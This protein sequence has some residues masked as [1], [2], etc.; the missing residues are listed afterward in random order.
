MQPGTVHSSIYEDSCQQFDWKGRFFAD[1]PKYI[2]R[3]WT[4]NG[5]C[6]IGESYREVSETLIERNAR[7]L[8]GHNP[9][10]LCLQALPFPRGREYDGFEVAVHDLAGKLLGVPVSSLLGGAVRDRIPVSYWTGRRTPDDMALIAAKALAGGFTSL[11]MKC[12]LEDPHR[13][14]LERIREVCGPEFEVVLDP[15]QR[16][17]IPVNAMRIAGELKGFRVMFEDP[18]ARWNLTGYRYLREHSGVP[19]AL[20][21]HLPYALHGQHIHEVTLAI[22]REAMDY[23]NLGGGLW[24]FVK[25]A[26]MAEISGIPVWHGT[27]VD[28]GI[29]DASYAHACSAAVACTLPSDMVGNYLREDDLIRQPLVYENG[30]LK[31]PSG[32]GLGVELDEEALSRYTIGHQEFKL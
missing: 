27:E 32:P 16:F 7:A 8:L 1:Y 11:K 30:F 19:I 13:E 22:Q 9:L 18:L 5:A 26:A 28:L 25:M 6:G 12:A 10:E 21:V 31:V 24:D 3:V 15:N 4:D 29:L 17:G 2:Y 14:R 20:H 23:L